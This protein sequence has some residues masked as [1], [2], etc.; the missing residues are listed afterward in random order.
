[1]EYIL[2]TIYYAVA[3]FIINSAVLF[4][5]RFYSIDITDFA[6]YLLWINAIIIF[7]ATL[8]NK[9]GNIFKN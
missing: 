3:V 2:E 8:P 4:I 9:P 7:I 6:V 1:M 5:A